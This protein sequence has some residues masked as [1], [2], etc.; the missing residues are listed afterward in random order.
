[1]DSFEQQLIEFCMHTP[2]EYTYFGIGSCPHSSVADLGDKNDQ[3]YPLFVRDMAEF[4]SIRCILMDP[5]FTEKV[6]DDYFALKG[7]TFQKRP[8]VTGWMYSSP[9]LDFIVLPERFNHDNYALLQEM[10]FCVLQKELQLVVQ[11]YSGYSVESKF[12]SLYE[13][14]KHKYLYSQ[15]ILCDVSYGLDTGCG[16]D[17]SKYKPFYDLDGCFI[18]LLLLHPRVLVRYLGATK[19]LDERICILLKRKF[20]VTLNDYHVEYRRKKQ[21][22]ECW[23]LKHDNADDIMKEL[24]NKISELV[25]GLLKG[26]ILKQEKQTE[27]YELFKNYKSYDMYVWQSRVHDLI[28]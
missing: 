27:M 12:L 4:K 6:M 25:P 10:I 23:T 19:E 20:W 7:M 9:R 1:M 5:A 17:L 21:G 2:R 16:T 22:M 14:Y 15:L 13:K 28:R 3:L 24:Q 26:G 18:N 8:F 11:D